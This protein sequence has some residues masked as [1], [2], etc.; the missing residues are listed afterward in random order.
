MVYWEKP[1]R[2]KRRGKRAI[3]LVLALFFAISA[4]LLL[5]GPGSSLVMEQLQ[6]FLSPTPVFNHL[7]LSHNDT[8]KRLFPDQ[9][10]YV[11]PNDRLKIVEVDTSVPL[12][13]GIRLFSYG[14]DVNALHKETRVA[15]LLPEKDIFHQYTYTIEVKH[16]NTVIGE[17]TFNIAP[18]TKD[19][20]EKANRIIDAKKRLAFLESAV[21][22]NPDSMRLKLK[23]A[24]EYLSQNRW[25]QGARLLEE[26]L[27]TRDELPLMRKL[28]QAYEHLNQHDRVISTLKKILAKTPDDLEL[29]LRLAEIL[30][31]KGRT[32]EAISEYTKMLP[33]LPKADRIVLMKNIGYLSFQ[34]G[35]KNDALKWYLEAA[36]HDKNDPNLYYNIG[37]IY[38]ELG[39]TELAE[40]YLRV[41]LDLRKG[42][43][44]GRLRL[45]YSLSKKGELKQARK[46]IE[47][48]LVQDPK[49]LEALTLYANILEKQGD[50][51]T[52]RSVY[53]KILSH[54][55][56]NTTVLYNLGVLE[57]EAGNPAKSITCFK[58]ILQINPKD[59][60]A[61]EALFEAYIKSN[62]DDLAYEQ[63]VELLKSRPENI[64]LYKYIFDYLMNR[65]QFDT[66]A[67]YMQKG[68]TANPKNYELRQDLILAYL[69]ADKPGLA[70]REMEQALT[71]HPKD[72]QLLHQLATIKEKKGE[73]KKA[74]ELYKRILKISPNDEKASEAYL[75]LR[76]ELLSK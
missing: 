33:Q 35:R 31:E 20:L 54:N 52:L 23:L 30:E 24:D 45:A 60:E 41:A 63:A 32:R 71:L 51:Q 38:D 57:A 59:R 58:Q 49:H 4:Y 72:T 56:K 62:K 18:L 61:R 68:V 2:K 27:K 13:R 10:F 64:A 3:Y 53:E 50:K 70:E 17:L 8:K 11:H 46:Y 69:S 14:F 55:K 7:V 9:T 74:S 15:S 67:S 34:T 1:Y 37:S 16:E 12:N 5:G 75:R 22:E 66:A 42:D 73:L 6:S 25:K 76:L 28:V 26:I 29:M 36:K 40:K 65:K 43:I 44:E 48:I 19:W 21:K 39:K 47:E